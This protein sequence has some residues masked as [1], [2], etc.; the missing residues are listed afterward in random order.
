[1]CIPGIAALIILPSPW[2]TKNNSTEQPAR[3]VI[4]RSLISNP[5]ELDNPAEYLARED[6]M[7]SKVP[8]EDGEVLVTVLTGLFDGG[9]LEKQFV[10]YR[11][12]L[13]VDSPIYVTFIDYN[14]AS[15]SYERRWSAQ[16]AATRPGTVSLSTIDLVGDKSL[17]VLLG[18]MN[19]QGQHTLTIFRKNPLGQTAED[20]NLFI[21]IAEFSIEGTITVKETERSI[22]YHN[23][24]SAGDSFAISAYGRDFESSNILDQ[25]EIT[26]TYN[27]VSG[28][29]E[30]TR[31]VRIPGSQVEQ[32]R[33]RELLGSRQVFEEFITGLWYHI[34]PQGTVNKNQYIYFSP[35]SQEIIFYGD[36]ILQVFNWTNSIA[37]RYGL[38]VASQNISVTTLKRSIDIELESLESIRIRVQEDVRLKIG[39]NN[40][41][42]G[43]YR[44]APPAENRTASRSVNAHLDAW[45][46]GPIGKLHLF[47]NGS[48]EL[49]N[50]NNFRQGKYAFFNFLDQE[51]LELNSDNGSSAASGSST[52]REI[53]LI[54]GEAAES[55][56]R[57]NLTLSRVR[58]GSNGIE[59]LHERAITLTLASD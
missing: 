12:L 36:E 31:S 50:G 54:E 35:S 6:S 14:E 21:K 29:Y 7:Y 27:K 8:L 32:R 23:G 17:C 25:V 42:D 15:R 58:L 41:W 47:S 18:G 44:K 52:G 37:T 55:G 57:K 2:D 40:T 49:T 53:Y 11:N 38:Y 28:V 51:L 4:P 16:T 20:G 19:A 5:E 24:Q 13:E 1:V 34:T 10:A 56:I 3:I 59:S 22:S 30:Q 43:S 33:V 39:V 9:P 45:Y 48:Y 46:D 26:Y